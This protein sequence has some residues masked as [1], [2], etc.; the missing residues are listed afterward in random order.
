MRSSDWSSDVCSS[1]LRI[2]RHH[3]AMDLAGR[4]IN[5]FGRGAQID[6]HREYRAFAHAHALSPFG[7]RADKGPVTDDHRASP[8]GFERSEERRVRKEVVRT[9]IT[10]VAPST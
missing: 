10:R 6:P 9:V 3:A 4:S 1:D 5:D 8:Q 2:G 7:A